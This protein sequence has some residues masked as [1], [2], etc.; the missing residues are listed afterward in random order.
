MNQA[1]NIGSITDYDLPRIA[2]FLCL[3]SHNLMWWFHLLLEEGRNQFQPHHPLPLITPSPCTHCRPLYILLLA[4][5]SISDI[6]E[7]FKQKYPK[8]HDIRQGWLKMRSFESMNDE[9]GLWCRLVYVWAVSGSLWSVARIARRE[10]NQP[11][12]EQVNIISGENLERQPH[13]N[14]IS[15]ETLC[16]KWWWWVSFR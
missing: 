9:V 10:S 16:E 8:N 14:V 6:G 7:E 5:Q 15:W 11:R 3:P 4:S 2:P 13:I 1:N 12:N